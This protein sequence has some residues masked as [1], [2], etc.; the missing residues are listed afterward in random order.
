M[1]EEALYQIIIKI[2]TISDLYWVLE[3]EIIKNSILE[4]PEFFL[5]NQEIL[6]DVIG[7][8][9]YQKWIVKNHPDFARVIIAHLLENEKLFKDLFEDIFDFTNATDHAHVLIKDKALFTHLIKDTSALCWAVNSYPSDTKDIMDFVLN[10]ENIFKYLIGISSNLGDLLD[11]VD[12][13]PVYARIIIR[14]VLKDKALFNLVNDIVI[15]HQTVEKFP[16]LTKE[17]MHVFLFNEKIFKD[18]IKDKFDLLWLAKHFPDY[19]QVFNQDSVQEAYEAALR[20]LSSEISKNATLLDQA[21]RT[22]TSLFKD[23]PFE[24]LEKI[25]IQTADFNVYDMEQAATHFA[26]R[27]FKLSKEDAMKA[28]NANRTILSVEEKVDKS[29]MQLH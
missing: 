24:I 5:A 12:N 1:K 27:F 7:S 25:V 11:A 9:S 3:N 26:R 8:A 13:H 6:K 10:N 14:R 29:V 19:A 22:Q 18:V 2:K 4:N 23:L 17:I 20:Y 28:M 16:D 21:K 15:L